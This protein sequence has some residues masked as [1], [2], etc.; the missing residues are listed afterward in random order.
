MNLKQSTSNSYYDQKRIKG[1]IS[2]Q[3]NRTRLHPK[4]NVPDLNAD[5]SDHMYLIEIS[6]YR[7]S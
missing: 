2:Q 1:Q 6:K 3:L 4:R 5:I 7:K